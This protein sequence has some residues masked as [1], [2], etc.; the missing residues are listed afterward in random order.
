MVE[1]EGRDLVCGRDLLL[2]ASCLT[3]CASAAIQEQ[4]H[5]PDSRI[6]LTR[7]AAGDTGEGAGLRRTRMRKKS[8]CWLEKEE[9]SLEEAELVWVGGACHGY[10]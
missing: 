8:D 4:V 2:V 6:R 1:V 5:S 10:K 7:R 3:S 9:V